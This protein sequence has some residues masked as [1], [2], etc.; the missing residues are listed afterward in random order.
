MAVAGW[1]FFGLPFFAHQRKVTWDAHRAVRNAL[2]LALLQGS[3]DFARHSGEALYNS[4]MAGQAG[5][6]LDLVSMESRAKWTPAYAG[7]TKSVVDQSFPK[8]RSSRAG[9]V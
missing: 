1:A 2:K 4:R 3:S 8:V 9:G 6:H 5:I 7:V